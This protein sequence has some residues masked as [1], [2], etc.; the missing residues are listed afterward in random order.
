MGE[1]SLPLVREVEVETLYDEQWWR[2]RGFE[3]G[4]LCGWDLWGLGGGF[5]AE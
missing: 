3:E 2:G 1:S 5:G 4:G